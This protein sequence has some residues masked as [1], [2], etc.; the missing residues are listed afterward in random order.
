M[1]LIWDLDVVLPNTSTAQQPQVPEKD[2]LP[3]AP[4]L[5]ITKLTSPCNCQTYPERSGV[6]C[7]SNESDSEEENDGNISMYCFSV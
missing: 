4:L 5:D 1:L 6:I 2:T 7:R 3:A